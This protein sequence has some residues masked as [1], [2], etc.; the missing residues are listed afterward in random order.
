MN[1][2]VW[3]LLRRLSFVE[4]PGGWNDK[5]D[6]YRPWLSPY[7][8]VIEQLN[9]WSTNDEFRRRPDTPEER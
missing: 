8:A 7:D 6:N 5:N 2:P 3:A 1:H 9:D 4:P